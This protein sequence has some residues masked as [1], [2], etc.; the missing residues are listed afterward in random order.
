MVSRIMRSTSI[1]STSV[2]PPVVLPLGFLR[3]LLL[4]GVAAFFSSSFLAAGFEPSLSLRRFL[5]LR[6]FVAP[7]RSLVNDALPNTLVPFNLPALPFMVSFSSSES[8][9]SS[10]SSFSSS[11]SASSSF[12]S[13]SSS[14]SSDST[15]SLASSS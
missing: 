12:S 6:F 8:S 15:S 1:S 7:V 2:F 3:V 4:A 9:S 10:S 11:S 13:S 5:L 14:S